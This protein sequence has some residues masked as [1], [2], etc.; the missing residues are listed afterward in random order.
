MQKTYNTIYIQKTLKT[1]HKKLELINEFSQVERYKISIQ[2]SIAILYNNLKGN[3]KKKKTKKLLKSYS[4]K[5]NNL[6]KPDQEGERL[7]C[8]EI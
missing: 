3:V 5:E 1:P 2:Q 4:K 7:I 8:K 6:N